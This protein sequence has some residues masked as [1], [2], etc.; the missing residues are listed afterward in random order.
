MANTNTNISKALIQDEILPALQLGLIPINAISF[1]AVADK[2]LFYNDTVRVP[3]MTARTGGTFAGN[4]ET[5]DS[6]TTGKDVTI[7]KPT[8]A[9]GYID[10]TGTGRSRI[11]PG[12][13]HRQ[14]SGR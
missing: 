9:S 7:G 13:Q 2:P 4:W 6:T 1:K 14:R 8:F 5:G 3:V 11:V 10:P 12:G